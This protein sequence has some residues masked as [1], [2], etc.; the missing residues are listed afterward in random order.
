M[1]GRVDGRTL[2]QLALFFD[3]GGAWNRNRPTGSPT[4]LYSTGL[5]L[6]VQPRSFL[7]GEIT[8][9]KRL[10]NAERPQGLQGDGVQ[11]Q[12]VAEY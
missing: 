3:V 2:F 7:R 12:I 5:A 8:W 11:F 4:T 1:R 9:A 10:A 6:R